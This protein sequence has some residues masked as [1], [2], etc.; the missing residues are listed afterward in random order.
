VQPGVQEGRVVLWQG[1]LQEEPVVLHHVQQQG[2]LLRNTKK[3]VPRDHGQ[4]LVDAD[5]HVVTDAT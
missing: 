5:E 2:A 4:M 1:V 3:E